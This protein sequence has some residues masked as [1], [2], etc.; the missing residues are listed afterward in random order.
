MLRCPSAARPP[1]SGCAG[2]PAASGGRN[3]GI[4]KSVLGFPLPTPCAAAPAP[5]TRAGAPA[6]ASA[7]GCAVRRQEGVAARPGRCHHARR[8]AAG[9]GVA[10]DPSSMLAGSASPAPP[11]VVGVLGG[12]PAAR[13]ASSPGP[14]QTAQG[15]AQRRSSH[16]PRRA[17]LPATGA[18]AESSERCLP[19]A[20]PRGRPPGNSG[21]ARWPSAQASG[22][23][24]GRFSRRPP[25]CRN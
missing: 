19:Q 23:K 25:A 6:G 22:A 1:G 24:S 13:G 18:S 10:R 5:P 21:T 11:G 4:T 8:A 9:C 14:A 2:A 20:A 16:A 17:G 12:P 3:A 15:P 7:A